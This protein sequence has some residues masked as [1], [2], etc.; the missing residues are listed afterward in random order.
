ME[1]NFTHER[2]SHVNV[3]ECKQ[4]DSKLFD[5]HIY[6]KVKLDGINI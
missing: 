2:A 5:R 1:N 4:N 3:L 6:S